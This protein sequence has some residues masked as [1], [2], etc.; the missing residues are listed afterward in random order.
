MTNSN[1][2]PLTI[3]LL[4]KEYNLSCPEASKK[5]LQESAAYLS[6][7][8]QGLGSKVKGIEQIAVM[9]ALN[10]AHEILTEKK[11]HFLF[12]ESLHKRISS[13]ESNIDIVLGA[14]EK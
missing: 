14:I 6:D 3:K 2:V 5:D 10:M 8:M 12:T 4:N 7:Q 1:H 11:T 13:L 9:T